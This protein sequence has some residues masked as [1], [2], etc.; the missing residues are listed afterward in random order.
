MQGRLDMRS[1]FC[2]V[3][4]Y[5]F[6]NNAS[7]RTT[8][9]STNAGV[10]DS[11]SKKVTQVLRAIKAA[12][13]DCLGDF[14]YEPFYTRTYREKGRECAHATVVSRFLGG[15]S[16]IHADQIVELMYTS[17]L[18]YPRSRMQTFSEQM[19]RDRLFNWAMK[20]VAERIDDEAEQLA[21]KNGGLRLPSSLS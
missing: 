20:T 10:T 1:C 14:L 21:S 18:S 7:P 19:A 11:S 13:F 17:S 15:H 12:D 3:S 9:S 4:A 16:R 2:N 6:E 5:D 8:Q